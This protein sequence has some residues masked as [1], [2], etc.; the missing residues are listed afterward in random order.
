MCLDNVLM[1]NPTTMIATLTALGQCWLCIMKVLM[2]ACCV[3]I[4]DVMV[5]SRQKMQYVVIN[6]HKRV[7]D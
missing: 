7:I 4:E 6:C 5:L 2:V 1:M 3:M